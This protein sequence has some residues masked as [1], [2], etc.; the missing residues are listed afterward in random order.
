MMRALQTHQECRA[1]AG[2]SPLM[3]VKTSLL[4][5][6]GLAGDRTVALLGWRFGSLQGWSLFSGSGWWG[7]WSL[8][9][10]R[11][12]ACLRCI[13]G[14]SIWHLWQP[15]HLCWGSGMRRLQGRRGKG[16]PSFRAKA[17]WAAALCQA[18]GQK[19]LFYSWF[20]LWIDIQRH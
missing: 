4:L 2:P 18:F 12:E 6:W 3:E 8:S 19:S 13:A 1:L 9:W 17:Y 15:C 14:R 16:L 5:L 11:R 10:G 7:R 20:H